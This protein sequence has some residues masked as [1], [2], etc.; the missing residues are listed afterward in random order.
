MRVR[1]YVVYFVRS[2]L[3]TP[4]REI[5]RVQTFP[6][7]TNRV[8]KCSADVSLK[9]SDPLGSFRPFETRTRA[10]RVLRRISR[11]DKVRLETVLYAGR[12]RKTTLDFRYPSRIPEA[13]QP[14]RPCPHVRPQVSLNSIPCPVEGYVYGRKTGHRIYISVAEN[15]FPVSGIFR[16]RPLRFANANGKRRSDVA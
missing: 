1:V 4:F 13:Y 8:L 14:I 16:F 10:D 3:R 7:R 12:G 11:L 9:Y 2:P 5:Y 15:V 6:R